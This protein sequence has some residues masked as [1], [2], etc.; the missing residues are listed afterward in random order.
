[1]NFVTGKYE[2]RAREMFN[3]MPRITLIQF[4]V[5]L[6]AARGGYWISER[7]GRLTVKY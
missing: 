3:G 2:V 4:Y 7:G 5:S 6:G 1:M